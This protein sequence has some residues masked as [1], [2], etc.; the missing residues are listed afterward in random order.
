MLTYQ[1]EDA[2]E[3]RRRF[4]DGASLRIAN[5]MHETMRR[6]V[7]P[8]T[9]EMWFRWWQEEAKVAKAAGLYSR[10]TYYA[11]AANGLRRMAEER[12]WC[13]PAEGGASC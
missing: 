1:E 2:K 12:G 9:R 8:V 10:A 6:G 7:T 3:K 11:D 5:K 4:S 13:R